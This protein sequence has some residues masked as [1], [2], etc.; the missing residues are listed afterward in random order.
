MTLPSLYLRSKRSKLSWPTTS[1]ASTPSHSVGC[2]AKS[3]SASSEVRR[4]PDWP[5]AGRVNGSL[6]DP[7]RS[8]VL[9]CG[10]RCLR[11][12][13]SW[14]KSHAA[15][16]SPA[17]VANIRNRLL[18]TLRVRDGPTR[19][20][21]NRPAASERAAAQWTGP[22]AMN[23]IAATASAMPRATFLRALARGKFGVDQQDQDREGHH[24]RA[25]PEVAVVNRYGDQPAREQ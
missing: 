25:S 24:A 10:C 5:A 21:T 1:T 4:V 12:P 16:A 13:H 3:G 15:S 11:A 23:P 14:A 7:G 2:W 8:P 22:N 9:L 19:L 6:G 18:G 20:P 17:P